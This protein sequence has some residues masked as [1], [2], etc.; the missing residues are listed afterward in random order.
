[1]LRAIMMTAVGDAL[2]RGES[3]VS[4]HGFRIAA[5][6]ISNANDNRVVVFVELVVSLNGHMI[7]HEIVELQTLH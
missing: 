2:L 4:F 5:A 3:L 6:R 7:Y 1:M